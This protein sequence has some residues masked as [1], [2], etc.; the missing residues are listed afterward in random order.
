MKTLQELATEIREVNAA[1]GWGVDFDPMAKREIPGYLALIDSEVTEAHDAKYPKDA[2]WELGDVIVR[3]LDL[4]ELIQ[5]G[6]WAKL[7]PEYALPDNDNRRNN[8][9]ADL[10]TLYGQ[11]SYALEYY[12]KLE[13][14]QAPL[15]NCLDC[16]LTK[17]WWMIGH[18]F[19]QENPWELIPRI[20]EKNRNRGYRHGGRRT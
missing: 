1:N 6:Y 9:E 11:S 20:I 2:A 17:A 5:P 4:G 10:L 13:D 8:W 16:L 15:L 3:C 19:P 7:R 14:W 18:Y 12:R